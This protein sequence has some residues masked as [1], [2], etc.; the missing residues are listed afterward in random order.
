[1]SLVLSPAESVGAASHS[2]GRSDEQLLIA[3][4]QGGGNQKVFEE[5]ERRYAQP[6]LRY[7]QKKTG[8]FHL[9]QD[10]SQEVWVR[11]S[12]RARQ[13]NASKHFRPW[14]YSIAHHAAIDKLRKEGRHPTVSLD[15]ECPS[16]EDDNDRPGTFEE[17][18][19]GNEMQPSDVLVLE[20]T[21]E[22]VR[23]ALS[24]IKPRNRMAL[25]LSY[26]QGYSYQEIADLLTIPME[27][28]KSRIHVGL[29]QLREKLAHEVRCAS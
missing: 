28:V 2:E 17:V 10:V 14:L 3:Y 19:E 26:Y 13:F 15:N 4:R 7:L 20:E 12:Q 16:A 24:A 6:L 18:L 25:D 8:N 9:A 5:L 1:M 27:T 23:R 29:N 11:V 22:A 21:R